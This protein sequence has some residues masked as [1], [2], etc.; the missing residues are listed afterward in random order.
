MPVFAVAKSCLALSP[1]SQVVLGPRVNPFKTAQFIEEISE[2]L[3]QTPSNLTLSGANGDEMVLSGVGERSANPLDYVVVFDNGI[4][5][6]CLRRGN[7]LV[8]ETYFVKVTTKT[9]YLHQNDVFQDQPEFD[10]V[11]NT[12][13]DYVITDVTTDVDLRYHPLMPALVAAGASYEELQAYEVRELLEEHKKWAR[14]A[15]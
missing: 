14:V 2:R 15:G 10:R 4:A 6:A 7:A 12:V 5:E 3:S 11:A 8:A 9:L 13:C 1:E